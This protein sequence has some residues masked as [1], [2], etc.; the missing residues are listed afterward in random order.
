MKRKKLLVAVAAMLCLLLC[1]TGCGSKASVTFSEGTLINGQDVSGLK[2]DEAANKLAESIEGY[3]FHLTMGEHSYDTT[4]EE[5]QMTYNTEADLQSLL[6]TQN[7]DKNQVAFYVEDL[8]QA[9]LTPLM[10]QICTDFDVEMPT[11]DGETGEEGQNADADAGS[12]EA[13]APDAAPTEAAAA[14]SA[15]PADDAAPAEGE[16]AEE[17]SALQ[18]LDPNA[19]QN[20]NLAYDAEADAYVIVPDQPGTLIDAT[21]VQDQIRTAV[22]ELTAELDMDM[23]L[24]QMPAE[25]KAQDLAEVLEEANARLGMTLTYT[26]T[27]DGGAASSETVSRELLSKLFYYNPVERKLAVDEELLGNYV[28]ELGSK[29]SVSGKSAPFRTTG[30]STININVAQAG[31]SVDTEKLYADL[32]DCLLNNVS[33]TREASYL[34]KTDSDA[35]FWGG[36]YV[37]VDQ[38]SQHMWVYKNGQQ[39]VSCDIVSGCVANNTRTPNGCFKIFAKDHSRYLQGTNTNGTRYKAWVDYFMPFSGG[40]GIHDAS[41]RGSFGGSIYLYNGS[42]GCVGVT[43]GNAKKIYDN[44]SVGTHVVI[45]GGMSPNQLPS[46][47][48]TITSAQEEY[49]IEVGQTID[50]GITTNSDGSCHLK[51][52]KPGVVSVVDNSRVTGVAEGTA[53]VTFTTDVTSNFREGSHRVKVRVVAAGSLASAQNISASAGTTSLTAGG[54]TTKIS[55]SGNATTPSFS[56]SNNGVVTVDGNGVVTPVGVG[57]ATVTVTCPAGGGYKEGSTS[58]TFNVSAPEQKDQNISASAGTTSLTVGGSTTKIS[59]SGN[60]TAPSFSSESSGVISVDSNGVVTPVG[61]GTAKVYIT[62]PAGNG[63]K[64][65]TTSITFTVSAPAPKDQN[66]SVSATATNLTVNGAAAQISV[67]GNQ[68]TPK[69]AANKSGVVEVSENGLVTPVGEGTVIV[70]ITCPAGNGYKESVKSITFTVSAAQS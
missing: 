9:N 19:P 12:A 36:N 51:S 16:A 48:P 4:A 59:V 25:I 23:N 43:K 8:Y 69:F 7:K 52:S 18:V 6:D 30:G 10:E 64:E 2:V 58:I 20:A 54:S 67:S 22:E 65:G 14:S 37:E 38:T 45:Y 42:H 50:L 66:V 57:S 35:G 56:S 13:A 60:I 62:C 63:Y 46:K 49:V 31:S 68:T 41:W 21:V 5:L 40:C 17:D 15:A 26:F 47:R 44:V 53:T 28:V 1:L 34:A 33:G 3:T 70:T 11:S 29:Y 24:F 32:M 61:E 27:P 55:V 39:V